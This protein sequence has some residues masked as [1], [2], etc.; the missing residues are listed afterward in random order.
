[1]K[2]PVRKYQYKKNNDFVMI[3][4]NLRNK[5]FDID[6]DKSILTAPTTAY[7]ILFKIISDVSSD[8]FLQGD[9]S[10]K[11]QITLFEKDFISQHSSYAEFIYH[12]NEISEKYYDYDNIKAGLD[13]LENYKRGWYK[14]KST[15]GK[16]IQVKGGVISQPIISEAKICFLVSAFWMKQL[17]VM[18]SYNKMFLKLPWKLNSG[19]HIILALFVSQLKDEGTVIKF[20]NFQEKFDYDYETP[21]SLGQCVLKKVKKTLDSFN[22]KSFN[23]S[24]SGDKIHFKPYYTTKEMKSLTKLENTKRRIIQKLSYWKERHA[25][26]DEQIKLIKKNIK[27]EPGSFDLIYLSAYKIFIKR[28]RQLRKENP[29]LKVTDFQGVDFIEKFQKCIEVRY[30]KTEIGKKWPGGFPDIRK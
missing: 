8:Q 18:S 9:S 16:D 2:E 23:Y 12:K 27:H 6:N 29:K 4:N 5:I 15:T 10:K 7:K 21:K 26:N 3:S 25:L 17:C 20:D 19:R 11:R 30:K 24:I 22:V 13:F 1:M 28:V 14:S